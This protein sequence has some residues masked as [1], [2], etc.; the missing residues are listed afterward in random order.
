VA[1]S[2]RAGKNLVLIL[3]MVMILFTGCSHFNQAIGEASG[4]YDLL[5]IGPESYRRIL[6]CFLDFKATQGIK[7]KFHP[8]ELISMNITEPSIIAEKLHEFIAGEYFKSSIKYLILVGTYEHVPTKYVYSPGDELG[9]ADF[10][11]KPSDWYY[12]VPDWNDSEIGLL[13]GNIPRIAVGRLPVKNEEELDRLIK[14]IIRVEAGFQPGLF[15]IL[16]DQSVN[17]DQLLNVLHFSSPIRVNTTPSTLDSSFFKNVTFLVTITHG[18]WNTLFTRTPEGELKPLVT[19]NEVSRITENYAL[20]YMAACFAGALDSEGECLARVLITSAGGPALVI[21]S[22]RTE[23]S[24]NPILPVF[25]KRFLAT[26]DVGGS[27]IEA[28]E[29]YLLDANVFSASK[30][31]FSQ[32]N[33]YLTK[34]IYGDVSWRVENPVGSMM[35][36]DASPNSSSRME[37]SLKGLLNTNIVEKEAKPAWIIILLLATVFPSCILVFQKQWKSFR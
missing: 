19:S 25:W 8:I 17:V 10:N 11:Y 30:P 2:S 26:G 28:V 27:F 16:R 7:A 20:H 33:F 14:K 22:S 24:E 23:W 32:Y 9:M 34:V 13:G 37:N 21:A 1:N 36:R 12:G 5:V 29:T 6:Q 3:L 18:S 35:N 15:L 4:E 31:S